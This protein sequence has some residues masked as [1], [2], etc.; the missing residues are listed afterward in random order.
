MVVDSVTKIAKLLWTALA[1]V[2][3]LLAAS[4]TNVAI[5]AEAFWASRAPLSVADSGS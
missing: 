3:L 1:V 4:V 2:A 5:W